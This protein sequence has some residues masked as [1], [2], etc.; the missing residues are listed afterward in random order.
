MGKKVEI[1]NTVLTEAEKES[2]RMLELNTALNHF[3]DSK[4]VAVEEE[5]G[6]GKTFTLII[7]KVTKPLTVNDFAIGFVKHPI[8]EVMMK[9][10]A[11]VAEDRIGA[12]DFLLRNSL[13]KAF[14][15]TEILAN[16][17][18]YFAAITVID[19]IIEIKKAQLKKN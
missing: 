10:Y 9:V 16:D 6:K 3:V 17:D 4:K 15:D 7:P 5:H 1:E 19:E 11:R 18:L 13:I 8:R 2:A 12:M 14:S